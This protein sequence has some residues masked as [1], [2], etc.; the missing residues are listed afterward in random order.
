MSRAERATE[1]LVLAYDLPQCPALKTPCAARLEA[2][3]PAPM[4]V[5]VVWAGEGPRESEEGKPPV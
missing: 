4:A 5:A 2:R 1:V 3:I